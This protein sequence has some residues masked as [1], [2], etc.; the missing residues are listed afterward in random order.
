MKEIGA[1]T[2]VGS[3]EDGVEISMS[4]ETQ[5]QLTEI[6]TKKLKEDGIDPT[7]EM[8]ESQ[9][10]I[11]LAKALENMYADKIK[12]EDIPEHARTQKMKDELADKE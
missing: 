2:V 11:M 6:V 5:A 9:M 8:V 4:E 3:N 10:Q 7:P 12:I 1:I